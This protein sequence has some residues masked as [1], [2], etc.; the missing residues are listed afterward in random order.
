MAVN[1]YKISISSTTSNLDVV[2]NFVTM[3]AQKAGFPDDTIHEMEMAVDE[4]VTN[5][6][7][8]ALQNDSSKRIQIRVKTTN[9][10]FIIEIID[11]SGKTFD[12]SSV[13]K[14]NLKE[15]VKAR[16]HGGL[17]IHLIR[18]LMDDVEFFTGS[19][20]YNR[21]KLVKKLPNHA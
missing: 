11:R 17:G 5:V 8:H 12:P 16:K 3:I 19:N 13:Q 1:E 7:K 6:I 14:V 4:A 9:E 21:V 10:E 15:F 20:N 2:R 18:N